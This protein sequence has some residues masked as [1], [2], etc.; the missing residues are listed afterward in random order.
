MSKSFTHKVGH[1]NKIALKVLY[2]C[3]CHYTY[4]NAKNHLHD[5]N[6]HKHIHQRPIKPGHFC[7]KESSQT[8]SS[9]PIPTIVFTATW[10]ILLPRSGG[11]KV[12]GGGLTKRQVLPC[13][14]F[15]LLQINQVCP[16]S[17]VKRIYDLDPKQTKNHPAVTHTLTSDLDIFN[18]T[19]VTK[20]CCLENIQPGY[21]SKGVFKKSIENIILGLIRGPSG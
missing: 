3:E 10:L 2:N 17:T 9:L 8:N 11:K 18:R 1:H 5:L 4:S 20:L 16:N 12:G 19:M 13:F 15:H 21:T 14:L 7:S 6:S